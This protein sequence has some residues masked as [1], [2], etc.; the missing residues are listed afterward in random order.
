M[1]KSIVFLLLYLFIFLPSKITL[2]DI[3]ISF[4]DV[5]YI[6]SNS[7]IGKKIDKQLT[8]ENKKITDE[9]STYKNKIQDE[10]QKLIAQKKIISEEEFK[11]KTIDLE[12]KINKYNKLIAE[13]NEAFMKLKSDTKSLFLKKLMNIVGEYA[14]DNSIQLILNKSDVIIGKSTLDK[15]D[16]ILEL[17]NIKIKDINLQ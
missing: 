13:K 15:S 6:Y 3:S 1:K 10:K 17:V 5:D 12:K 7:T 2:A 8:S 16:D 11:N 4:I 14:D 9:F